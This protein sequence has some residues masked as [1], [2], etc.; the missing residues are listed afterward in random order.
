AVFTLTGGADTA[1]LEDG[2]AGKL[3]LRSVNGTFEDT[4]FTTP[5]ST[6]TINL[7][8]GDDTLTISPLT[9]FTGMLTINGGSG[10]DTYV[11]AHNFNSFTI[12]S[13]DAD[14]DTIDLTQLTPGDLS[15]ATLNSTK[16]VFTVGTSTITQSASALAEEINVNLVDGS[17]YKSQLL[18]ALQKISND[19]SADSAGHELS[20]TLPLLGSSISQLVGLV[21]NFQNLVAQATTAINGLGSSFTLAQVVSA[22]N[23]LSLPAPFNGA[24]KFSTS[25]RGSPTSSSPT[26]ALEVF[27]DFIVDQPATC[28]VT[29]PGCVHQ[30]VT[31]NLGQK[32]EDLGLTLSPNPSF[33]VNIKIGTSVSLGVQ[34]GGSLTAFLAPGGHI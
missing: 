3:R 21:N 26:D 27:V 4:E 7:A 5:T 22:L 16:T 12:G 1:V 9:G 31:L 6:L 29:G 13:P 32:A 14:T 8:G 25:Y 30:D 20:N 24:G 19:A 18:S 33:A 17:T 10:N 34:P 23:G 2:A 15:S 11:A 28:T